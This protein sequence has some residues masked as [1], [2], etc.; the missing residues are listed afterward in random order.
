M[1]HAPGGMFLDPYSIIH[2]FTPKSAHLVRFVSTIRPG[3]DTTR[4]APSATSWQRACQAADVPRS[5]KTRR[6]SSTPS[7]A[8]ERLTRRVWNVPPPPPL[9]PVCRRRRWRVHSRRSRGR[10]SAVSMLS[11]LSDISHWSHTAIMDHTVDCE[12][13]TMHM[14]LRPRVFSVPNRYS[15]IPIPFVLSHYYGSPI[16]HSHCP[17]P[18]APRLCSSSAR[19]V[20]LFS[21]TFLASDTAAS[22]AL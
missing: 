11:P 7:T 13:Y 17:A 10:G 19:S 6:T 9:Q 5:T 15:H 22:L 21:P 8:S 4:I 16:T 2:D 14:M 1:R 20:N 3:V 12:L 18:Y